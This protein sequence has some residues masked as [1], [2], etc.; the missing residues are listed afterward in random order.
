[1]KMGAWQR[2]AREGLPDSRQIRPL[3]VG[4]DVD[5]D[6]AVLLNVSFTNDATS[7]NG[8]YANGLRVL[9]LGR[10]GTTVEHEKDWHDQH[11]LMVPCRLVDLPGFL[12]W[13]P[14]FSET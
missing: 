10:A 11:T 7:A 5:L 8:S 2:L 6:H 1:M 4:V 13:P 3:Q 9:L 12:S 14:S